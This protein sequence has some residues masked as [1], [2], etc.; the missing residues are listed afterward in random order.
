MAL[1]IEHIDTTRV[2]GTLDGY[3]SFEI[4]TDAKGAIAHINDWT[5]EF[6]GR[7][8]KNASEMRSMAYEVLARYRESQRGSA[9]ATMVPMPS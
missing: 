6:A 5:R 2:T 8:V 7:S 1:K 9:G 4:R 3:H